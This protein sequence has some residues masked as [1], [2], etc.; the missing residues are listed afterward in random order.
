MNLNQI[1]KTL[2]DN[3][4]SILSGAAMAGVVETT[5]LAVKATP[6]AHFHLKDA[7]M[8]KYAECSQDLNLIEKAGIVYRD[9]IPTAICGSITI[10]CIFAANYM[11]LS[12]EAGLVATYKLFEQRYNQYREKNR[13]MFGVE[14]DTQIERSID[15][16]QMENN[17]PPSYLKRYAEEDGAFLCYEPLTD[18]YFL[19]TKAQ[20]MW[21]EMTINKILQ[22]N[23]EVTLNELLRLLPGVDSSKPQGEKIGWYL[24]D[25]YYE[26]IG[27][28]WGFYG[29]PWVDL[30]PRFDQVDGQEVM[31][32]KFSIAPSNENMWDIS[33]VDVTRDSQELHCL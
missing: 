10:T 21:A 33:D 8:R 12:K 18:Q 25:S 17:P 23:S 19:A 16:E 14:N 26:F 13:E 11:H 2:L 15:R 28:N 31:V 32:I 7:R 20:L 27:Y 5:I 22:Q 9:Y 29:T 30:V 3:L 24:D 6:T 4:P 1:R